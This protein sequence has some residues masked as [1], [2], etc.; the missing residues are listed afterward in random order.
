ME[1]F[2]PFKKFSTLADVESRWTGGTN[3]V[4]FNSPINNSGEFSLE[5]EATAIQRNEAKALISKLFKNKTFLQDVNIE[6]NLGPVYD[7]NMCLIK[8]GR[9][10][11]LDFISNYSIYNPGKEG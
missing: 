8:E 4:D 2:K 6:T 10:Q 5:A 9:H 11:M 3:I 1:T 7:P